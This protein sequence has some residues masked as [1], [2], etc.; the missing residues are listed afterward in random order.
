MATPI[1][2]E[3][4]HIVRVPG[5]ADGTPVVAAL[6]V[7]VE[8]IARLY[9]AGR[10]PEAI[11]G[12][13]PGLSLAAVH[14]AISYSLDHPNELGEIPG[15]AWNLTHAPGPAEGPTRRAPPAN[16]ERA[17]AARWR[18][19]RVFT[20]VPAHVDLASELIAERRAAA[21]REAPE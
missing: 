12:A 16:G 14:D 4:P 1:R 7:P 20:S 9:A 19:R 6:A 3:H 5:V 17:Q 10:S 21:A 8:L 2:T 13:Y 11:A 18:L 15:V